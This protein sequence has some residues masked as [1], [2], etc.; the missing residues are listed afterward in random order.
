MLI[1]HSPHL[2]NEHCVKT[3]RVYADG[4]EP[5]Q[6]QQ[7]SNTCLPVVRREKQSA[8]FCGLVL[9]SAKMKNVEGGMNV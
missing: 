5:S 3:L 9:P 2:C 1:N 7:T 4:H 8:Q 6:R